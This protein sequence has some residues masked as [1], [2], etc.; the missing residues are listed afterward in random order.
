LKKENFSTPRSFGR[1]KIHS[2]NSD[3]KEKG[4]DERFCGLRYCVT[5]EF[6]LHK[7]F[8]RVKNENLL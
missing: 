4:E 7:A 6:V 5:E 8:V 3:A 1:R 2:E